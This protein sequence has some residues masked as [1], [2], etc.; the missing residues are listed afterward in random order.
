MARESTPVLAIASNFTAE[1]IEDTL[2]FW[3]GKVELPFELKFASYS[4]VFQ[5]LMGEQTLLTGNA[6][7]VNV[8]LVRLEE[9]AED[10]AG[11]ELA[12]ALRAA[13]ARSAVPYLLVLCPASPAALADPAKAA[14]LARSEAAVAEALKDVPAVHV[15]TS[16]E[17]VG[18]YPLKTYYSPDTDELG[19][20]PYTPEFF[21]AMGTLVARRVWTLRSPPR[22]VIVL[23]C[24]GTLW[25]GTVGE[26]GPD[27]LSF[28]APWKHLQEFMVRQSEAG[29]LLCVC[30]K[31]V[32]EDV[33]AAFERRRAEM[34]LKKEHIV[35]WRVNWTAKSENLRSLAAELELGID[36]FIMVDDN[37][38]ECAEI[39]ANCP[40]A[41]TLQLPADPDRIPTFLS[42]IWA[43]DHLKVTK[44]DKARTEMYRANAQR[45][46]AR[47]SSQS[48]DAF[49]E[50]LQLQIGIAEADDA[51]LE[52][53]AQLTQ[54]TNQFNV[55]GIRRT[56]SE[57]EQLRQ[58][59]ER[60]CLTV[61]VRDRF[62]DY[63]LVGVVIY[64][65]T[66][67]ALA[68]DSFL[69]SCRA[70]GRRVEH[71][72]LAELGKIAAAQGLAHV[73]IP[74]VPTAKNKPAADFLASL[75][76]QF[77][78]TSEGAIAFRIPTALAANAGRP[79]AA[80]APEPRLA[81]GA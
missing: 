7:G 13:A 42:R 9:W 75:G 14:A 15:V 69:L 2:A 5:E 23:D 11:L 35:G 44:E 16:A 47:S 19:H 36:S 17:L 24:D 27:G 25:R 43:F 26:D 70:L 52:R 57:L 59:G 79:A 46:A 80:A 65:L 61:Q 72:I 71:R 29:M 18:L 45:E 4:Q 51:Q 22:K 77:K 6:N 62:G 10:K 63:G 48:L 66:P 34:P 50:G 68:V 38:L 54:R 49:L 12:S 56:R 31:N 33:D 55:S 20:V 28:D 37:P 30:S 74:F 53:V 41:L 67:R 81:E 21:T 32:T 73:E 40:E 76:E 60:R 39:S 1:P 78:V 64:A 3:L 58:R 8:V